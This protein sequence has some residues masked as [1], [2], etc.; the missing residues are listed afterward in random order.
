MISQPFLTDAATTSA[1][2]LPKTDYAQRSGVD[3]MPA[4]TPLRPTARA[5]SARCRIVHTTAVLTFLVA[6][7]SPLRAADEIDPPPD[8]DESAEQIAAADRAWS[9]RQQPQQSLI[10]RVDLTSASPSSS[11]APTVS[12]ERSRL[13]PSS[14][15]WPGGTGIDAFGRPY[16]EMGGVSYRWWVRRGR[17]DVGVGFGTVGYLVPPTEGIA[18]APHSTVYAGPN[19][20][21]YAGPHTLAHPA[22]AVTVGWRYQFDERSTFYADALGARR[23]YGEYRTDLYGTKVG[24]EFKESRSRLGFDKGS[25]GVQFDSGLRMSFRA[26]RGGLGLYLRSQF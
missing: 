7:G 24:V 9:V 3:V 21:M 22:A 18:A 8:A 10:G 26:R 16:T 13:L 20:L 5:P 17:S 4:P 14:R 15:E 2:T 1:E 6:G 11:Y 19:M 12:L 25:L 23:S